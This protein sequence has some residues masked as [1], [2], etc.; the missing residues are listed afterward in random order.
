MRVSANSSPLISLVLLS[1]ALSERAR[2]GDR[3]HRY[4]VLAPDEGLFG[5]SAP[6]DVDGDG[7]DDLLVSWL[8]PNF[9]TNPGAHARVRS[10]LNGALLYDWAPTP[11]STIGPV[12]GGGAGDVDLDGHADIMLATQ[13]TYPHIGFRSGSDGS[14]IGSLTSSTFGWG[15]GGLIGINIAAL[16]DLDGDGY[17]EVAIVGGQSTVGREV[18]VVSGPSLSPLYTIGPV[19][20]VQFGNSVTRVEDF[21]GD[22]NSDFLV[23][24][25]FWSNP[26][27]VAG[28]MGVYSGPTG[29]FLTS[30]T[31]TVLGQQVGQSV[32]G[33]GDVNGDGIPEVAS[34]EYLPAPAGPLVVR[35]VGSWSPVYPNAAA[36]SAIVRLLDADGDGVDDVLASSG[37]VQ[38]VI[39]GATGSLIFELGSWSTTVYPTAVSGVSLGDVNGDG[40]G[41]IGVTTV[42]GPTF[43]LPPW[44]AQDLTW[45]WTWPPGPPGAREAWVYTAR[46]FEVTGPTMVGGSAQFDLL[47][48][49]RPGRA[50]QVVFSLEGQVPGVPLGPFVFP[51]LPDALVLQTAA[52]GIGGVLDATGRAALTVPIPSNPALQGYEIKASGV[53]YDLAGPLGIGCVLTGESFTIQ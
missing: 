44:T 27:S 50:F 25:P 26:F 11:P 41:D 13:G 22:G 15:S 53:V 47:V 17:P 20:G 49:K 24:A 14:V 1:L 35:T 18:A 16:G 40:L 21:D 48:P 19:F 5:V 32:T 38:R 43:P 51:L 23:G 52:L 39:S 10:G 30:M 31:G 36:G 6:G 46:N 3:F 42:T 33:L 12:L 8:P 2:A 45:G 29:A 7:Y 9:P 4:L 37:P 34:F 28:W